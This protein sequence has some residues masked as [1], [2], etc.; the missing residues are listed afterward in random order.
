[1]LSTC[2]IESATDLGVSTPSGF[3]KG[4][5]KALRDLEAHLGKRE[6]RH[7]L[8]VLGLRTWLA[9]DRIGLSSSGL[10]ATRPLESPPRVPEATDGDPEEVEILA[11]ALRDRGVDVSR[12]RRGR[13]STVILSARD[14]GVLIGELN[15]EVRLERGAS[16]LCAV[17]VTAK[18]TAAGAVFNIGQ[19]HDDEA[20]PVSGRPDVYAFVILEE[21]RVWI[22][23]RRALA[24]FRDV[25]EGGKRVRM[26]GLGPTGGLRVRLP[27]KATGF[28][29][30]EQVFPSDA[31][32]E[33]EAE[34][35]PSQMG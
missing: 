24:M 22:I 9:C 17:A 31:P 18:R 29:V 5:I 33:L 34:Q 15:H 4:E 8:M 14:S 27:A 7:A 11:S 13:P 3:T 30:E 10:G 32:A 19:V 12:Y 26:F 6:A 25:L 28:D 2:C 21:R 1:M 16:V 20:D 23:T 35:K